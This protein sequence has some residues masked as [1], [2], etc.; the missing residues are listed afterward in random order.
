MALPDI[1]GLTAAELNQLLD[2]VMEARARRQDSAT[3]R[4][5]TAAAALTTLIGPDAP[6]A[7]SMNNL[8]SVQLYTDD[9]IISNAALAVRLNFRATE[10]LARIVRDIVTVL[11][12]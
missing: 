6:E 11:G 7:P 9:Q 8:T 1:S 3:S 12:R 2:Q 10:Q 5:K 4:L